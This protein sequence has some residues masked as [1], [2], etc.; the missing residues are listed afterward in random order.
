MS[1]GY[2][3]AATI[4]AQHTPHELTTQLTI[5]LRLTIRLPRVSRLY[6]GW[7][8]GRPGES[9]CHR[10]HTRRQINP[11]LSSAVVTLDAIRFIKEQIG[12]VV[13]QL[14]VPFLELRES[15]VEV[16]LDLGAVVPG[17]NDM[18]LCYL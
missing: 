12:A 7:T 4:Q 2:D 9:S 18:P 6:T 16:G 14:R 1:V 17:Y 10:G 11:S 8:R 15:D 13:V 3:T 5:Q